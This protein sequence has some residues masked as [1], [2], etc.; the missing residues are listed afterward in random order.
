M[1]GEARR[2]IVARQFQKVR[3][4]YLRLTSRFMVV[5]RSVAKGL[6]VV[7]VIA[8]LACLTALTVRFGFDH[9]DYELRTIDRIIT[10]VQ[11]SFSWLILLFNLALNFKETVKDSR[12]VK[13][14][15]DI[16]VLVT[17]FPLVYPHPESP[18]IPVLEK[19]LYN[20]RFIYAIL[21]H[22]RRWIFHME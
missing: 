22:M 21:A 15:V 3:H 11:L 9:G 20:H 6:G 14:V 17:M 19:I 12:I 7:A 16:A 10:G 1:P 5:I 8:S 13:W 4:G 18:W 2:H